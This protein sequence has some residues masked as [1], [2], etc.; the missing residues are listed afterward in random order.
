[1]MTGMLATVV[2]K[3]GLF[4]NLTGAFACTSLA[5]LLPV[6]TTFY[7]FISYQTMMYN[8]CFADTVTTRRRI[9]HY[10]LIFF[11]CICGL[12]SFVMS[13]VEIVKAFDEG[14]PDLTIKA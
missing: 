2:P 12:I 11:G 9:M 13:M 6:S 7:P 14:E 1:M 3:F 8:K 5:F 4:I 10:V